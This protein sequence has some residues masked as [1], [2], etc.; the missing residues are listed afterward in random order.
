MVLAEMATARSASDRHRRRRAGPDD[1]HPAG[2]PVRSR[3]AGSAHARFGSGR[4]LRRGGRSDRR[5]GAGFPLDGR[6]GVTVLT[7]G[8]HRGSNYRIKVDE[9]GT[10]D[11]R[12]PGQIVP[13]GDRELPTACQL[14]QATRIARKLAGW[15]ITG[16]LIDKKATRARR[17]WRPSGTSWSARKTSRR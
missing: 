4:T 8:N 5:Q 1:L 11:D 3:R 16:T 9:D 12:L 17:R 2:Q 7:L 15:S 13:P 14:Q 6:A 10:A